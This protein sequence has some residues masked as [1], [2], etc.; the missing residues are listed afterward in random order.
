MVLCAHMGAGE[1]VSPTVHRYTD[2]EDTRH[3]RSQWRHLH[4]GNEGHTPVSACR[5]S[6]VHEATAMYNTIHHV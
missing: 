4:Q 3:S 1:G 2:T 5:E 6:Y